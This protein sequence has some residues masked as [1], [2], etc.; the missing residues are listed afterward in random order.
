[1]ERR[2]RAGTP[3]VISPPCHGP[4]A[5]DHC[6]GDLIHSAIS[7]VRPRLKAPDISI[8][9]LTALMPPSILEQPGDINNMREF[10][11]EIATLLELYAKLSTLQLHV[12]ADLSITNDII[13]P[14]MQLG[15][16]LEHR[17]LSLVTPQSRDAKIIL[18]TAS[19]TV[20][21]ICTFLIFHK[22]PVHSSTPKTP[23]ARLR[24]ILTTLYASTEAVFDPQELNML[25]WVLWVGALTAL[26]QEW[27][28]PKIEGLVKALRLNYWDELK[29]VLK[30]FVWNPRLEGRACWELCDRVGI[31]KVCQ[32][33]EKNT[34][35]QHV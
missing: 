7:F 35:I 33:R 23:Q 27:Y 2:A 24:L 30:Y 14:F 8:N 25:L 17:L 9:P 32:G 13:L 3:N 31:C 28:V 26:E 12:F 20:L 5:S 15:I 16:A 19:H 29:V 34:A 11:V 21:K 6:S 22:F 10:K 1:M 18:Y 4:Y